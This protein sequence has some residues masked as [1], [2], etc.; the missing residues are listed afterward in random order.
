MADEL[1]LCFRD[2]QHKQIS[3][4]FMRQGHRECEKNLGALGG[5]TWFSLMVVSLCRSSDRDE[6]RRIAFV[7]GVSRRT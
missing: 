2:E 3:G 6:G 7:C 5:V 4:S 1:D